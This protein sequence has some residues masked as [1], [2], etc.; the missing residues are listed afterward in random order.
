M[1]KVAHFF[2]VF[3]GSKIHGRMAQFFI[4]IYSGTGKIADFLRQKDHTDGGKQDRT[5]GG[6]G[7][8]Y[9][10]SLMSEINPARISPSA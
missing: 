8:R 10:R 1:S 6:K 9:F 5:Y 2:V 4:D 7:G 3:G